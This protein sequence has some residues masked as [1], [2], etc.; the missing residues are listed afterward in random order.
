MRIVLV[1]GTKSPKG[2]R[3]K[4]GDTV[5]LKNGDFVRMTKVIQNEWTSTDIERKIVGKRF[6][7]V[8]E[9]PKILGL[10]SK[11]RNEVY[12]VCHAAVGDP[13]SNGT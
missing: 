7:R 11:D 5:E 2:Y 6:R 10:P 13:R 9:E 4:L 3:V 12:W 8:T 1:E